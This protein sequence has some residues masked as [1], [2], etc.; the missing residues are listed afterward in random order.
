MH[1]L[2]KRL[3]TLCIASLLEPPAS[4]TRTLHGPRLGGCGSNYQ[5]RNR[6][7]I[8]VNIVWSCLTGVDIAYALIGGFV[9]IFSLLSLFIKE[10]LYIGE[11]TVAVL[12]GIIFGPVAAN[13]FDPYTWGNT[14]YITLEV[15]RIVIVVQVFAV[16]VELP[17]KYLKNHWK[18]VAVML[19]PIMASSWFICAG[20]IY[21]L[22]PKLNFV[23]SLVVAATLAPTDPVLASSVVGKGKFAERV[24][25]H[26]RNLLS[27]ES[28]CNDG[29]AF[30]FLYLGLY[31]ILDIDVTKTAKDWI[32]ITILYEC[33]F[34]I[35]LGIIIGYSA[36]MAIRFAEDHK[37]IDRES[38]LVFYFVLALF[39]TG[40]GTV[41]GVDD[42][43]VAFSAG[44]AF[45]WDGWFSKKTE[46]SHV[47]NVIDL[48][49][50]MAFFVYFGAIIPWSDFN[51]PDLSITP[52]RLVVI[53]ILILLFRR[54]PGVFA[55]Y[56][57]CPD[58]RN[59]REAMFCGHFGPIGVGA[60]FFA[61]LAR[62]ELE[63][64]SQVPA[65][66]LPGATDEHGVLIGAIYPIVTFIVLSSI[67]VH[68]SSIAVFTLGK[69][70]NTNVLPSISMT[71]TRG[72]DSEDG[73]PNWL[74]RLPRLELGQSMTFSKSRDRSRSRDGA[75][76]H[77]DRSAI[78][79]AAPPSSRR[80]RRVRVS[81]GRSK[82]PHSLAE[83]THQ[84][85]EDGSFQ[86]NDDR[87]SDEIDAAKQHQE[88][89]HEK[90]DPDNAHYHEEGQQVFR[91]G[92]NF[93]VE[94]DLGEVIR[95]VSD[96]SKLSRDA[97]HSVL[98]K[99]PDSGVDE[100]SRTQR[101]EAAHDPSHPMFSKVKE[102]AAGL[103]SAHQ[104]KAQ[105]LKESSS[106]DVSAS[107]GQTLTQESS[108]A[109][110]KEGD[111]P[112]DEKGAA[113]G[114][115]E[116]GDDETSAERRRRLHA[117]G[118]H[119]DDSGSDAEDDYDD[120]DEDDEDDE[121]TPAERKRRMQALGHS[122]E[123]IAATPS[124]SV[125]HTP[126]ENGAFTP[127]D[128][129]AITNQD[130]RLPGER[131]STISFHSSVGER[132]IPRISIQAPDTVYTADRSRLNPQA[133]EESASG[134]SPSRGRSIVWADHSESD[135]DLES[136]GRSPG[137][138]RN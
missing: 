42:F 3:S 119:H 28:G 75:G 112:A 122:I 29:M 74:Q 32:L 22:I 45:A 71:F 100:M 116:D 107:D 69:H 10:R 95:V 77:V 41:I 19:L 35:V 68:G 56:K 80:R 105:N 97:A 87:D 58:I 137:R 101:E 133:R 36:R 134:R 63:T 52:W 51:S 48:L 126:T 131:Q 38:F 44:A 62:A 72:R 16:G 14:D 60:L 31:I 85:Q 8:F 17:R 5:R 117:L 15:A 83:S 94:D 53:A 115:V 129:P 79:N 59:W 84:K 127:V 114:K 113:A 132:A 92:D 50:N 102:F 49:L 34:G 73:G 123:G 57:I 96:P 55:C 88:L 24:P 18:G 21:A 30:P 12:V 110:A 124:P 61:I 106:E 128:M 67:L 111:E 108:P 23:E 11:A 125:S 82:S 9:T 39:C 121:E 91:E 6:V 1:L 99:E 13:I 138:P 27:C 4:G 20:F 81:R 120:D 64:E 104:R 54:I 89:Q 43:L 109:S 86:T 37:L 65:G 130:P 76:G 90:V 26:I 40:I 98:D 136:R 70:I 135:R 103:T 78:G 93:I 46:E 25:G 33:L 66:R 47:S 118:V 7:S 2:D